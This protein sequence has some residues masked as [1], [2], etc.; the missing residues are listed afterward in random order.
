MKKILSFVIALV[1]GFS[2]FILNVF[3]FGEF[4][5]YNCSGMQD[6]NTLIIE[7]VNFNNVNS[8][9]L[10]YYDAAT[11]D[12]V[13]TIKCVETEKQLTNLVFGHLYNISVYANTIDGNR[14]E[15]F[16]GLEIRVLFEAPVIENKTSTSVTLKKYVGMTYSI[17]GLNY[18]ESSKF[19]N[20]AY[21]E[22]YTF[23]QR[24]SM[25]NT[26]SL[27]VL[28]ENIPIDTVS[29]IDNNQTEPTITTPIIQTDP[30]IVDPEQTINKPTP[31]DD[32]TTV[33]NPKTNIETTS[34][35]TETTKPNT[36]TQVYGNKI[37]ILD[38]GGNYDNRY[39]IEITNVTSSAS[40]KDISNIEKRVKKLAGSKYG[41]LAGL[42]KINFGYKDNNGKVNYLELPSSS[43]ITIDM[44]VFDYDKIMMFFDYGKEASK[45]VTSIKDGKIKTVI[46]VDPTYNYIAVVA[47]NGAT[48]TNNGSNSNPVIDPVIPSNPSTKEFDSDTIIYIIISAGALVIGGAFALIYFKK[49]RISKSKDW[50]HNK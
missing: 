40:K 37:D 36:K 9:D 17:D 49:R 10:I 47:E 5:A 2:L 46:N 28:I 6:G 48:K 26:T 50:L 24:D 35:Q 33:T 13:K 8:Y 34:V 25:G 42:Y 21:G 23:Y 20:L 18:S 4:K 16:S 11:P 41:E 29:T 31:I 3:A 45:L 12:D 22:V 19:E 14:N 43:I 44:T 32:I 1:I 27:D 7:W 30:V 38:K 15:V 39:F